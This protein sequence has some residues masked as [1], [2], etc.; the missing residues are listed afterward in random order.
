MV[1]ANKIVY[2]LMG[3]LQDDAGFVIFDSKKWTL[4]DA[5]LKTHLEAIAKAGADAVRFLAWGVWGSHPGQ[6]KEYQFSPYML[7]SQKTLWDLSKFNPDYFR[8]VEKA[9]QI[10]NDCDMTIIFDLFDNCQFHGGYKKWSPW[11]NNVQ[12]LTDFYGK[13][14]DKYAKAWISTWI[15]RRDR[16][17]F[18]IIFGSNEAEN[19]AYPDF[20]KRVIVPYMKRGLL[21]PERMTYGATT[22]IP[23]EGSNQEKVRL[24]VRDTFGA[25]TERKIIMEDHGYPFT[26]SIPAWAKK[27]Y[28]KLYSDDGLHP[29]PTPTQWAARVKYILNYAG[30]KARFVNFEHLPNS[31]PI[32][33][34]LQVATIK[35]IKK[36]CEGA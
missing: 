17:K 6:S 4:N 20:F 16:K 3:L 31:Y 26:A 35:A 27:I 34:N 24:I 21:N 32:D 18:D 22:K 12:G 29:R 8:I 30:D 33:L 5:A 7:N 1:Q 14:A 10:I 28:E 19:S 36:A 25:A 9:M 23:D 13:G 2:G 15:V 11:A